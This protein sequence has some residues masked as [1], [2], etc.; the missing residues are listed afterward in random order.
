MP[1]F[2]D[3]EC[4]TDDSVFIDSIPGHR[5]YPVYCRPNKEKKLIE[6]AARK[7]ISCYLPEIERC[8]I[9][10]GHRITTPV[11]MFTGYSFL[12]LSR[13]ENWEIKKSQ[14]VIRMLS[15]DED[16]ERDLI[17]ELNLVRRFE[18]LAK[19]QKVK[20]R[21]ELIPGKRVIIMQGKLQ[22]IEGIV[23]RRKNEMEIIV[24]LN[25]LGCSLATVEAYDLEIV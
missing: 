16:N 12:C 5:W 23:K 3:T 20:I 22:G 7:G 9:T 14:Y 6:Y 11:P 24:N 25:F 19:T 18:K 1:L 15:V 2:I 4:V 17:S 8:R 13:Q 21:P 10:R